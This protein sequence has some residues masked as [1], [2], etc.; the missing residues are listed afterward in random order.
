M[1]A[2]P[3]V[4]EHFFLGFHH[5]LQCK[6]FPWTYNRWH[7]AFQFYYEIG[8]LISVNMVADG[9]ADGFKDAALFWSHFDGTVPEHI[10]LYM[11]IHGHECVPMTAH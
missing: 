3:I 7:P 6:D 11:L 2:R 5:A 4:P 10:A 8:R 9:F 1:P